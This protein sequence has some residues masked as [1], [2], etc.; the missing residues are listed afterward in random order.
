MKTRY[1]IMV[2]AVCAY[3]GVFLGP[4]I[5]SNVYCDFIAQ[6][7]CTSRITGVNLPPFNMIPLSMPSDNE[8]F[9]ENIEGVMEPC[10]IEIGYFEWPFHPPLPIQELQ[11]DE[12]CLD[13]YEAPFEEIKNNI[14][15]TGY[16]ICDVRLEENKIIL[17]LHKFFK[18]SD[19]EKKIISQIPSSID[20]EIVYHEGYSDYFIN[21]DTWHE[22]DRIYCESPLV[23]INGECAHVTHPFDSSFNDAINDDM[24]ENN[25]P[26]VGEFVEN[27]K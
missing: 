12:I 23:L 24:D 3:F 20:Y 22:C 13:D 1:K 4:V 16:G 9:F 7:M 26:H 8:C 18:D 25:F 11:C 14:E 27:E 15:K 17:D 5:T 21:T 6:E 10:Y 2:I 19:P